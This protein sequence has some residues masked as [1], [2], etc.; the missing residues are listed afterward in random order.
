MGY[1]GQQVFT[2][3]ITHS[4]SI[5]AGVIEITDL[6]ASA[7]AQLGTAELYGFTKTNGSGS[8]KEDL[9]LTKTGG[10]DNISVANNDGT[11]SDLYDESFIAKSGLTFTVNSDG[12]LEVTI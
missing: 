3:V 1:I 10:T 5:D 7:Q 12:E 6:S 2:G 11:L 9:I 4:D 8:Q